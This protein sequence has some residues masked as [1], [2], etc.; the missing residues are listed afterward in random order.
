MARNSR[1]SVCEATVNRRRDQAELADAPDIGAKEG[2]FG[3]LRST[4]GTNECP[5]GMEQPRR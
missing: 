3:G 4:H 1:A 2:P 5:H